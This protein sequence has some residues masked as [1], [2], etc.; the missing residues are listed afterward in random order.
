MLRQFVAFLGISLAFTVA[1]RADVVVGTGDWSSWT[2]ANLNQAGGA[3]FWDNSSLDGGQCNI[4]YWLLGTQGACQNVAPGSS[5]GPGALSFYRGANANT[6]TNF[7]LNS[8]G[9]AQLTLQI[10]VAGWHPQ[11]QFGYYDSVVAAGSAAGML[12][13]GSDNPG[14]AAAKIITPTGQFGFWLKN[15]NGAILKSGVDGLVDGANSTFALFSEIPAGPSGSTPDLSRYW[16]AAEDMLGGDRDFQDFVVRVQAV[17]EPML[18]LLLCAGAG[19][20]LVVK[21]RN[22]KTA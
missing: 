14:N 5:P 11:N 2:A 8:P 6:A 16:I 4:G 20:L 7:E 15:A 19:A 9:G 3:G 12:Y 21:R 22:R 1:A 13:D 18:G 17:P 10:E